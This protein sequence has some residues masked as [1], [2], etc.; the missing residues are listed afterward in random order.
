[1]AREILRALGVTDAVLSP[2][3]PIMVPYDTSVGRV[4]HMDLY[5][6]DEV[7]SALDEEILEHLRRDFWV[8]EWPERRSAWFA[9][10]LKLHLAF[11]GSETLH[12]RVAWG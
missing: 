4:W 3:F 1:M 11:S 12:R 9:Q 5:R 6:L 7:G 2:T 8:V 10:C